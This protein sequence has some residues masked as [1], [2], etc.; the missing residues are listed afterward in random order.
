[1]CTSINYTCIISLYVS[2]SIY[3]TPSIEPT[4]NSLSTF[5]TMCSQ[6]L[7]HSFFSTFALL[8]NLN[9]VDYFPS[10]TTTAYI[11]T[12]VPTVFKFTW[13]CHP[14]RLYMLLINLQ[15][16][17]YNS[18]HYFY[19]LRFCRRIEC[20]ATHYCWRST[21]S[22]LR[23][24]FSIR[25]CPLLPFGTTHLLAPSRRTCTCVLWSPSWSFEWLVAGSE[26]YT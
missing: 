8:I 25:L 1:M 20:S 18:S 26:Y 17:L 12:Y 3:V 6:F 7:L 23:T 2:P 9:L 14:V 5:A 24:L 22:R 16:I 19:F 10:T 11:F 4:Y 15:T 21:S 13:T